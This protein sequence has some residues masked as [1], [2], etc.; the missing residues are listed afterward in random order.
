MAN[1]DNIRTRIDP[2]DKADG[3]AVLSELGMTTSQALKL[4]WRQLI[5]QRGLPFDVK[6]P[7]A[8]TVAALKEPRGTGKRYANANDMLADTL[9][10]SD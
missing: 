8:E 6:V 5:L 1:N 2:V 7:N 3:E 10:D 9:A 4:F